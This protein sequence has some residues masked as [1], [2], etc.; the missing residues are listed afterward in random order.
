M[1]AR[2]PA[3]V[4]EREL[5]AR[6]RDIRA[7]LPGQI[8]Q[9]HLTTASLLYGRLAGLDEVHR[10]VA[11]TLPFRFGYVRRAKVASIEQAEV[12]LPDA[13]LLK[14]DDALRLGIFARFLIMRPAYYG[15]AEGEPWLVANVAGSDRW[16]FIAAGNG[17]AAAA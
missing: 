1:S 6:A 13:L 4:T 14:Y 17:L 11:R 15:W 8:K 16:A 7:T 10:R 9:E 12:A 3:P 2:E 5:R